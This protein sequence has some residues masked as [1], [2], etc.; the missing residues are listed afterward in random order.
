[1]KTMKAYIVNMKGKLSVTRPNM[2][3]GKGFALYLDDVG[4]LSLDGVNVYV[5]AGGRKAL[6]AILDGG[7]DGHGYHYIYP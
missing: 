5:P 4:F 6:K 2:T 3:Y 1:M 7:L